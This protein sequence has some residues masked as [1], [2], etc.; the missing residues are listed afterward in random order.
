MKRLV[1]FRHG[2]CVVAH[3]D[4]ES[5]WFAGPLLSTPWISWTVFACSIPR[6]DP[7]RA[8]RF[9]DACNVLGARATVLPFIELDAER[10]AGLEHLDVSGF[11]VVVTHNQ[12]GE[13]GNPHHRLVYERVL[14]ASFHAGFGLLVS[15]YGAEPIAADRVLAVHLG[16]ADWQTKLAAI[17]CYDHT[18]ELDQKPKSE[19]LLERYGS[20]FDLRRETFHVLRW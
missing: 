11:D 8:L 5:M 15:G 13:Y 4:D 14:A 7:V 2:A 9:H 17:R 20:R 10:L 1:N 19:A 18:T 12:V 16:E 3:P 6:R